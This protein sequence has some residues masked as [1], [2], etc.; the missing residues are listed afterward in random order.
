MRFFD[1]Q[2][3]LNYREFLMK[4]VNNAIEDI[5]ASD[6]SV[7]AILIGEFPDHRNHFVTVHP[8]EAVTHRHRPELD[9]YAS[10][11]MDLAPEGMN[12]L[13]VEINNDIQRGTEEDN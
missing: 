3:F 5:A 2:D 8:F 7:K 11:V 9:H 12:L 13:V 6:E 1:E 10:L 4:T